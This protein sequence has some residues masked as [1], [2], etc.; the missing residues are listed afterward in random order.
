MLH[1]Y[2][3]WRK[4]PETKQTFAEIKQFILTGEL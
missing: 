3:L 4:L 1:D 2:I